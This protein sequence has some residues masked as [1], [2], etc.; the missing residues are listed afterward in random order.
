MIDP[1]IFQFDRHQGMWMATREQ[2]YHLD[3]R[4]NSGF[5]SI[6]EETVEWVEVGL[7]EGREGGVRR[8]EGRWKRPW[9]K[10]RF[11]VNDDVSHA[12]LCDTHT[13]THLVYCCNDTIASSGAV[14]CR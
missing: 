9:S 2:V 7:K 3:E 14:D 5:F 11:D 10:G 4:C 12:L 8:G 6:H 1:F 13:W